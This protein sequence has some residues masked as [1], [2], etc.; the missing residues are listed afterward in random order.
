MMVTASSRSLTECKQV[1]VRPGA[2][3]W[4]TISHN[5]VQWFS[6]LT[7]HSNLLGSVR[8]QSTQGPYSLQ[9]V[10]DSVV[11][12]GLGVCPM[13]PDDSRVHLPPPVPASS[14]MKVPHRLPKPFSLTARE[15]WASSM[16]NPCELI[17]NAVPAALALVN[18]NPHLSETS[19]QFADA[20]R[21]G[22]YWLTGNADLCSHFAPQAS[23]QSR[24]PRTGVPFTTP[25]PPQ[26]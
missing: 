6:I 25:G 10:S 2:L 13:F 19:R 14:T 11:G 7:A 18:L 5:L 3:R 8:K 17:R 15:L 1:G 12:A 20:L 21:S 23:G 9:G 26:P 4:G 16:G 24:L 22:K